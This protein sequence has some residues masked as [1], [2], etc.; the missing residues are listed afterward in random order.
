MIRTYIVFRLLL[1]KK[2]LHNVTK[3]YSADS[4]GTETGGNTLSNYIINNEKRMTGAKTF[5]ALAS[6]GA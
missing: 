6:S 4:E 3:H 2:K 5:K 1:E